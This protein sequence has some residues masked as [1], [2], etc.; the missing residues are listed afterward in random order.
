MKGKVCPEYSFT[1]VQGAVCCGRCGE[2]IS[3]VAITNMD[4]INYL[5]E[6]VQRAQPSTS[7]DH[8]T[9]QEEL[10]PF[11]SDSLIFLLHTVRLNEAAVKYDS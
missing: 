1:N 11:G 7:D 3:S 4:E 9:K 2:E 5:K 8:Q 6:K 10:V